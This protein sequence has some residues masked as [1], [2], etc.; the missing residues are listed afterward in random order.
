MEDLM[1]LILAAFSML[2]PKPIQE[3]MMRQKKFPRMLLQG[4]FYLLAI[5]ACFLILFL[6]YCLFMLIMNAVFD[7]GFT[8]KDFDISSMT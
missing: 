3:W 2:I 6:V 1:G 4:F 5:C 7:A 8:L